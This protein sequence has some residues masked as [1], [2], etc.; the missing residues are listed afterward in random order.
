MAI[1]SGYPLSRFDYLPINGISLEILF[2]FVKILSKQIFTTDE[3]ACS[4]EKFSLKSLTVGKKE[5][6]MGKSG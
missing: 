2:L 3:I 4:R 1:Y 5:I 6:I